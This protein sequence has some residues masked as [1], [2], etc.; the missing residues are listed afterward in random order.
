MLTSSATAVSRWDSGVPLLENLCLS[1]IA[2][3]RCYEAVLVV[4]PL[5][6]RGATASVVHPIALA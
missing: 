1:E 6:M 2:S 5:K 4:L 3:E